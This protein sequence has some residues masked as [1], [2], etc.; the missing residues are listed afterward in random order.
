MESGIAGNMF[1][2]YKSY[3]LL[4][5]AILVVVIISIGTAADV[6]SGDDIS[7][8][9]S[10]KKFLVNNWEQREPGG[11]FFSILPDY[12]PE[13]MVL[14][15]E[16][17]YQRVEASV[18]GKVIY[19]YGVNMDRSF[20]LPGN[21]QCYIPILTDYAGQE[22]EVRMIPYTK[23]HEPFLENAYLACR[24]Q[25]LF[26]L[27][28]D[29]LLIAVF[30]ILIGFGGVAALTVTMILLIRHYRYGVRLFGTLGV[31]MLLV[32][33]WVMTDSNLAQLFCG[34]SQLILILSFESFMLLPVPFLGF[35]D[36][37]C[38]PE[39]RTLH[40][41]SGVYLIN[42]VI[43]NFLYLTENGDFIHML[44]FTHTIM[45]ITVIYLL[46][47][48]TRESIVKRSFYS[49]GILVGVCIYVVVV[50]FSLIRF[51][52]LE[53]RDNG[54]LMI[55]GFLLFVLVLIMMAAR[56]FLEI[57][58]SVA[59]T[60]LFQEMAYKDIMTGFCNRSAYEEKQDRHPGNVQGDLSVAML[61]INN[62]KQIND[63]YGHSEGDS[64]I[65]DAA[66]CIRK[67][68]GEK[69]EYYRTGGDEFVVIFPDQ[70]IRA[71]EF[72]ERLE[73]QLTEVNRLRKLKLSI[74]DGYAVIQS[75]DQR[76]VTMEE[77]VAEADERMY[78]K[79]CQLK[80]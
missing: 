57:S 65:C 16:S 51:Y 15:V 74:A 4:I 11:S 1:K 32:S 6:G 61:D 8:H 24:G 12:L 44:P 67:A 45:V 73:R 19:Q 33:V 47:Y 72:E 58:E 55:P 31:F 70:A 62:L 50:V 71:E 18:N 2:S 75:S 10:D 20:F 14:V 49:E 42:F 37:V 25:V 36:T 64:L 5:S 34:N 77:L 35:I 21:I 7:I 66:N 68:Y 79:K 80:V 22:I 13:E 41:I 53:G 39:K 63:T 40:V 26:D 17:R 3:L 27:L 46:A 43:Q 38:A 48:M 52:Q 60:R 54:R 29:N 69:A 78:Q 76:K 30:C 9:Y 28:T 59:K 23:Y 56:K